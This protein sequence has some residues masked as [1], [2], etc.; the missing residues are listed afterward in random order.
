ML[1]EARSDHWDVALPRN[2]DPNA[3]MRAL[4]SGRDFPREALFRAVGKFVES[5]GGLYTTEEQ[6]KVM[7]NKGPGRLSPFMIPMLILNMASG[8]FSM[9]YKLRGPNVATCSACATGTASGE[10]RAS[11]R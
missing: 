11:A 6:H 8:L 7:L 4:T 2:R 10:T 3:W 9:Y 1:A 5:L